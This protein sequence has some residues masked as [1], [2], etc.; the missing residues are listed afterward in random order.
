MTKFVRNIGIKV[1]RNKKIRE[2]TITIV[3]KF[4]KT[5]V[6]DNYFLSL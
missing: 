5:A 4:K 3:I 6:S 2:I 1:M